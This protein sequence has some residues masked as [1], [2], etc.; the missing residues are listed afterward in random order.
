MTYRQACLLVRHF[1]LCADRAGM[2]PGT[3]TDDSFGTFAEH[4]CA[5]RDLPLGALIEALR[6]VCQTPDRSRRPR[7]H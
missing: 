1:R 3:C 5:A 4:Y 7:Y 2:D 6:Q